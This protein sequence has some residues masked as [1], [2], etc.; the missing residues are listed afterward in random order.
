MTTILL[1][2][3]LRLMVLC[4]LLAL[5]SAGFR[6]IAVLTPILFVLITLPARQKAAA[7]MQDGLRGKSLFSLQ[8]VLGPGYGR[9]VWQGV[10]QMLIML[11]WFLP[12]IGATG[13]LYYMYS[14]GAD[15]F[16]VLRM[17]SGLGGGNIVRGFVIVGVV[18]VLTFIP[19][20]FGLAFH[21]GRRH[22][23][24]LSG[25]VI[26]G[27]RGLVLRAWLM[28]LITVIPFLIAFLILSWDYALALRDAVNAFM[29]TMT[30]A[31]PPI[32]GK[33]GLIAA[34]FAVLMLPLMPLKSLVTAAAVH[35][36]WEGS[37]K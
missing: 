27:H 2:T 9:A 17:V 28:S 6:W 25:K 12:V 10:K 19:A 7:V 14:G 5:A 34:A 11:L 36:L 15:A 18:Y 1:E 3:V 16:T 21:S 22:E 23:L 8:L 4:P 20:L 33:A 24:A 13:Y 26:P 31:L 35:G 29:S 37:E 32:S 30:L